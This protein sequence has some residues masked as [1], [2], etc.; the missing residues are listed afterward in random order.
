MAEGQGFWSSV[1]DFFTPGDTYDIFDIPASVGN[2]VGSAFTTVADTV[3]NV[4]GDVWDFVSSPFSSETPSAPSAADT[5]AQ[6]AQ[7][8]A[9]PSAN[10]A[11]GQNVAA[12]A[13]APS[14]STAFTNLTT[15]Q[16]LNMSNDDF[17]KLQTVDLMKDG[18]TKEEMKELYWMRMIQGKDEGYSPFEAILAT[19]PILATLYNV[20]QSKKENE[21]ERRQE[22]DMQE[23]NIE[24]QEAMQES[25]QMHAAEMAQL[26]AD[27]ALRNAEAL[28]GDAVTIKGAKSVF[29]DRG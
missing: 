22:R 10:A 18:L 7:Q 19:T 11:T 26:Q 8:S 25:A 21:K 27:L 12:N 5:I 14:A 6:V 3:G 17:L 16:I 24:A 28:A 20:Y 2:F 9:A 29:K 15:E 4:A 23:T 1:A 13:P